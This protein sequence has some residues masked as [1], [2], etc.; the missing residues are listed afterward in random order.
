M[1]CPKCGYELTPEN[2]GLDDESLY[3][4]ADLV[5]MIRAMGRPP[6]PEVRCILCDEPATVRIEGWSWLSM[7]T[8]AEHKKML[9]REFLEQGV[10]MSSLTVRDLCATDEGRK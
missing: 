10:A 8:C 2:D 9:L 6:K 3:C 5:R 7:P 4:R 1:K